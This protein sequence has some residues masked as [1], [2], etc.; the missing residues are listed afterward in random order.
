[1][2]ENIHTVLPPRAETYYY[3]TAAGA[4]IDLIIRL[5]STEVWAVEIKHGVAP[6]P[7]KFYSKLCDD[8]GV[9]RKYI[10]Y[11]GEDEFPIGADVSMISLPRLMKRLQ[12]MA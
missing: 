8:V 2:V 6:K 1:V 7:G 4:E 11:G 9:T 12:A 3:R 10:V 5:T